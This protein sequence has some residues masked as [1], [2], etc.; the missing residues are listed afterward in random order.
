MNPTVCIWDR[1]T[2]SEGLRNATHTNLAPSLQDGQRDCEREI[3]RLLGF[4][5][6]AQSPDTVHYSLFLSLARTNTHSGCTTQAVTVLTC[7]KQMQGDMVLRA[8]THT[9]GDRTPAVRWCSHK[10]HTQRPVQSMHHCVVRATKG[11]DSSSPPLFLSYT[12][13]F[14]LKCNTIC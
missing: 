13:C 4:T 2:V 7:R 3:K 8:R 1:W 10:T 5:T 6:A 14:R 9:H 12:Q 11:Q